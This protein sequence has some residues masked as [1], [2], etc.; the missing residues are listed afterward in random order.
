MR[1]E[2]PETM[3]SAVTLM[4]KENGQAFV[5]AGGTDLLVKMKAGIVEPD[6]VVDIKKIKGIADI[7]KSATGF[8]IGAAVSGV[9]LSEN[10]ALIKAW[11]GVV[12]GANLIGSKQVQ[13]RCTMIGNL[14]NGSPA[15]DGVPALIA[16]QAKV[17]ISGPKGKRT[18]PVEQV[19]VSPGRTSL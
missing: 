16:A 3:K 15:A 6:L 1:Y 17:V 12:E 13:G 5:L 9:S 11:P 18:I 10:S 19:P 2:A 8:K 14:C 4:A 7:T